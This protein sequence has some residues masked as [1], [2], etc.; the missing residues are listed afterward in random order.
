MVRSPRVNTRDPIA[1]RRNNKSS[2]PIQK[3]RDTETVRSRDSLENFVPV[4]F[5]EEAIARDPWISSSRLLLGI[6]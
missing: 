6:K 3:Q 4:N 1:R 2:Q 5:E